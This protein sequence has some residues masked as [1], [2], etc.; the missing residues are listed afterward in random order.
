VLGIALLVL[1]IAPLVALAVKGKK[2]VTA[3]AMRPVTA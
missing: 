1:A 2:R 3:K